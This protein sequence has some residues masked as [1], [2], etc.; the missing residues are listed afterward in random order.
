MQKG[1]K[2]QKGEKII[3]NDRLQ[4]LIFTFSIFIVVCLSGCSGGNGAGNEMNGQY[5]PL[6]DAPSIKHSV[7]SYFDYLSKGNIA[8]AKQYLSSTIRESTISQR[9]ITTLRFRDFGSDIFNP[10]AP[11]TATYDF[12]VSE[13]GITQESPALAFVTAL[14]TGND[15]TRVYLYLTLVKE[16]TWLIDGMDAQVPGNLTSPASGS[17]PTGTTP[18]TAANLVGNWRLIRA[19]RAYN[20]PTTWNVQPSPSGNADTQ[21]FTASSTG[22]FTGYQFSAGNQV[23]IE[24]DTVTSDTDF[25]WTLSGTDLTLQL[26]NPRE[27]HVYRVSYTPEGYLQK[28]QTTADGTWYWIMQRF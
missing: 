28:I 2:P 16:E 22:H 15:G 6:T 4:S 21:S 13:D 12:V 14:Y 26:A 10:N 1:L 20:D 25:T 8:G 27:T 18:V 7:Q 5:F 11:D 3:V 9:I 23:W 17:T 19:S 24:S